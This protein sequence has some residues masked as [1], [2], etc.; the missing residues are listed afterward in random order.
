MPRKYSVDHHRVVDTFL[1]YGVADIAQVV[2][3]SVL[4]GMDADD[5]EAG[6][7][8]SVVKLRDVL[9]PHADS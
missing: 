7:S 8:I 5:G 3:E 1:F 6:I 2:L 4:R 9:P